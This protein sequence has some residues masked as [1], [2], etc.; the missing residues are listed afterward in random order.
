MMRS[1]TLGAAIAT[2]GLAASTTA[3]AA[4]YELVWS[5]EFNGSSLDE[6]LWSYQIGDGCDIGLCGWGNNER[7][8][9]Q[10][11][12]VTVANGLLTIEAREERNKGSAYTSGRIRSIFKGDFTY[13]RIEARMKLP[14]GQGIWP[15]FWMLPTDEAY[16]GW[17]ASGEIDIME[18]VNLGGTGGNDV[19][20][21]LHYGGSWP[22]N[23]YSGQVYTP[24]T[25]VTD[26]FHTYAV[27]W[28]P[29]EI[30]WYVDGLLYQTQT[31]WYS[32]NG[33]YPA[34]FD[35]DF[36]LLLNVAVGGDWPGDPDSTTVFPTAMQVDYV[37]VY[38]DPAI[39]G[40][41]GGET[42][43][44]TQVSA[45]SANTRR[46]KGSE[47]A[48]VTVVVTDDLGQPVE[49]ATV[50]GSLTGSYNET[51]SGT[52]DAS[53]YVVLQSTSAIKGTVAYEFC[54]GD[55]SHGSLTYDA[56]ANAATCVAYP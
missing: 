37:R 49:N 26:N 11:D 20:G 33:A 24:S 43:T 22:D 30:R 13:G 9:Y 15:A 50:T 54:V 56:S 7:Q 27:E 8:Y 2:L 55:I 14:A 39:S 36:H 46:V 48:E 34:P 3:F 40:D 41:T 53:G 5:D 6:S 32:D 17:A 47:A 52:T 16:G 35:Q 4:N 1:K 51:V 45:L 23:V 31:E 38:Q 25:S 21:T 44:S 12:N 10:A 19:H 28:E 42:A 18:A 29:G